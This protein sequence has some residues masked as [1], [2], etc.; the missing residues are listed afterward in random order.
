MKKY[1]FSLTLILL[2]THVLFSQ[3][4]SEIDTPSDY[5][6][7]IHIIRYKGEVV[8]VNQ[9]NRRSWDEYECTIPI[10]KLDNSDIVLLLNDDDYLHG[11]KLYG[12]F[13]SVDYRFDDKSNVGR[14]NSISYRSKLFTKYNIT[15]EVKYF[16]VQ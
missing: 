10:N 16:K 7:K 1:L 4:L 15:E 2:T 12:D 6:I 5:Q 13:I 11:W 3:T 9:L 8:C 14:I